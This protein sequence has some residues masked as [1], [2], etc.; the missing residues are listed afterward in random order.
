MSLIGLFMATLKTASSGSFSAGWTDGSGSG[1]A[2]TS[3]VTANAD[4]TLRAEFTINITGTMISQMFCVV[5]SIPTNVGSGDQVSV[6]AAETIKW[7]LQSV[8]GSG[9]ASAS[10]DVY[11]DA[12]G[13]AYVD[14]FTLSIS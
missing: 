7:R 10:V 6:S 1:V 12:N 8:F 13:G 4:A 5:N 14:S 3:E 2:D 9:T 11:D